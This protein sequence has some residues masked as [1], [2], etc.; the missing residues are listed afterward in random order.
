MG[1][2]RDFAVGAVELPG[3]I[4][5]GIAKLV[6]GATEK[7][8]DGKVKKD[9]EGKPIVFAGLLGLVLEGIG[10]LGRGIS[11]IVNNNK[12]AISTAFWASLAIGG[13][14]GLTLYLWPA[15]L[16][17]VADY[18][19]YGYSIAGIVGADPLL[20]MGFAATLAFAATT[21]TTYAVAFVANSISMIKSA[22]NPQPEVPE[23]NPQAE[24]QNTLVDS[25]RRLMTGLSAQPPVTKKDTTLEPVH[26]SSLHKNAK[27]EA[28]S[29]P[30]IILDNQSTLQGV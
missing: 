18:A 25:P 19:I 26:T 14:V 22:C 5:F 21:L 15:A 28:E 30:D 11:S 2:L 20:Q 8:K 24:H 10:A 1:R 3:T 12:A 9:K 23:E 6:F 29:V 13:A 4:L 16:T 27:E 7:Y 17:F